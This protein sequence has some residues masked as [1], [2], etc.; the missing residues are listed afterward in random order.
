MTAPE[1][2]VSSNKRPR[3]IDLDS[4]EAASLSNDGDTDTTVP[5]PSVKRTKDDS[6]EEEVSYLIPL[7]FRV[8][9][10]CNLEL[11]TNIY[12]H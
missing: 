8:V 2:P 6:Y 7:V 1:P 10:A 11:T 3:D 4:E 9:Q 5:G 12:L